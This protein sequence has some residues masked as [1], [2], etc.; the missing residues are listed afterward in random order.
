MKALSNITLGAAVLG[1]LTTGCAS[2]GG[3]PARE[4]ASVTQTQERQLHYTCRLETG[5]VLETTRRDTATDPA[6]LKSKAFAPQVEY[7]PVP[8]TSTEEP[9]KTA[10]QGRPLKYF[11]EVLVEEL[12]KAT[13]DWQAGAAKTIR[14]TTEDQTGVPEQERSI[15]LTRFKSVPKEKRYN[16][17]NFEQV[18]TAKPEVGAVFYPFR[19]VKGTVVS[20]DDGVVVATFQPVSETSPEGTFGTNHVLDKG[21]YYQ[22]VTEV[23]PGRLVRVGPLVG[24]VADVKPENFRVD[25]GHAF[26]GETLVCDVRVEGTFQDESD[27]TSGPIT[28]GAGKSAAIVDED[29]DALSGTA[30]HGTAPET[31]K[32]ELHEEID[33]LR[34]AGGHLVPGDAT[35]NGG[36]GA[37]ETA[38]AA[39]EGIK[40]TGEAPAEEDPKVAQPG[41]LA[42]VDFAAYLESGELF[43]TTRPLLAEDPDV[44]KVDWYR[45]AKE[46]MPVT[47]SVGGKGASTPG[48]ARA[49]VGLRVGERR[50]NMVLPPEMAYGRPDMK[51]VKEFP[52]K[53][54][55]PKTIE[56]SVL[57]YKSQFGAPPR[58][59]YKFNYNPY[60]IAKSEKV[61][62]TMATL[63]LSPS[64]DRD[65]AEFGT[66]E[67][68]EFEDRIELFLTPNLGA[69][70]RVGDRRGRIISSGPDKVTV[71]FNHPLA[72]KNI[73]VDVEV[74]SLTKASELKDLE[75]SWVED[76]DSGLETARKEDKPVIM[77]LYADWCTWCKRLLE[78]TFTDIEV[79]RFKKEFVWLKLD[80]DEDQSLKAM[81]D[82]KGFPM[83]VILSPEGEVV[84]RLSGFQTARGLAGELDGVLNRFGAASGAKA[85]LSDSVRRDQPM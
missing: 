71:D 57:D 66:T 46:Y 13:N 79:K 49:V 82:Q 27:D 10:S 85:A 65:E 63:S 33:T 73:V 61:G 68:K 47:I 23:E 75:I 1:L 55:I 31:L 41:D 38:T 9:A 54:S 4:A 43:Q 44:E 30:G 72:G 21:D 8:V 53:R 77:V 12:S 11:R 58:E 18:T 3:E 5:E 28:A 29:K 40:K 42:T 50:D 56:I 6:I 60:I 35:G 24:R 25:Y 37:A 45:P 48:L 39:V 52:R 78:E 15:W 81:Y 80:S 84:Q 32:T 64:K 22:V 70:F 2:T 34:E 36:S 76:H 20:V 14:V 74:L 19:E 83:T 67:V 16:A 7:G 59:G 69:P 17:D 51:K 62:G 26:G